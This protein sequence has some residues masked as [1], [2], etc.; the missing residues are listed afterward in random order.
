M[1]LA[2]RVS[3]T[4]HGCDLIPTSPWVP[5]INGRSGE[6]RANSQVAKIPLSAGE[7]TRVSEQRRT[8]VAGEWV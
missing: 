5:R 2:M 7:G 3:D 6:R 1:P 4:R 8:T